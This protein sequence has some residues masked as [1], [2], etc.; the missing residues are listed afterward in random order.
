MNLAQLSSLTGRGQGLLATAYETA[1]I[2]QQAEFSLDAST[3]FVT[4]DK[5]TATGS[6]ARAVNSALQRDAQSPNPTANSLALYGREFSIDDV[7]LS[8]ANV[9]MAPEGLRLL[10]DRR[11][12][13]GMAKIAEELET[14]MLAGTNA[15]NQ[16][17]GLATFVKDAAAGGQT[18]V[19]GFT[20]AE[21]AAMNI[22]AGLD[23]A[24]VASQNSFMELVERAMAEVP[25]CNALLCNPYLKARLGTIAKRL[26]AAGETRNSFGTPLATINGVPIVP[27]KTTAI[28]STETDGV[29]ANKTSLYVVRFQEELGV[30]FATNSGLK[31]D[32][33]EID[34]V[35][36]N[37]VARIQIFLNLKVG[38]TNAMR[39]ISRIKV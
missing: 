32:D 8:D 3:H 19:I 28:S 22:Q 29:D 9:G 27:V 7:Y 38:K 12:I 34:S 35:K 37:Q 15:D 1:P 31:F 14:G 6:A 39:R 30:C 16:M 17:L 5:H 26:G 25:G 18:A 4:P 21:Q 23:L 10:F 13:G 24:D 20:Q 36:P 11:L 33:I 2:L